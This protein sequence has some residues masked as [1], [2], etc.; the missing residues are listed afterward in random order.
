MR[1]A[2]LLCLLLLGCTS[3]P[4]NTAEPA[5]CTEFD[6]L[7][8]FRHDAKKDRIL[9]DVDRPGEEFL[10]INYLATGVGSNDIGLDRGQLGRTRV[11][12][13]E[14]LASLGSLDEGATGVGESELAVQRGN[15][16]PSQRLGQD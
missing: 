6:G 11:V 8:R 7:F 13:F 3:A 1:R 2:A 12:R 14:R 16:I 4:T 9:L 5:S 15:D 10:Y